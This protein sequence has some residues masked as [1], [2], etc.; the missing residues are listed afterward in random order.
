MSAV[1]AK[2]IDPRYDARVLAATRF[3]EYTPA[4]QDGVPVESESF[5]EINISPTR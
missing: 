1:M 4:T 5:V 2:R 3:W